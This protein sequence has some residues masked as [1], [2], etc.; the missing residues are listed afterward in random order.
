[1]NCPPPGR[2][3][4]LDAEPLEERTTPAIYRVVNTNDAGPGTLRTAI[5]K[6]NANPG[7]D[8]IAFAIP[9]G[10]PGFTDVN[11]NGQLNVGDYWTISLSSAL[12]A[13]TERVVI[14]GWSQFG[15][16]YNGR[17]LVA[18]RGANAGAGA[19]GLR[20]VNHSGSIVR[21]LVINLFDGNGIEITGGGSHRIQGNRIGTN[22]PGTQDRGN[23]GA[24]VFIT[25]S[26]QN[27]IGGGAPGRRNLIS[28]NDLQGIHIEGAAATGNLIL[29]NLIGT[30]ATGDLAIGNGT[31]LYLGDGIR[32]EGGGDNVI[33]GNTAKL[34]NVISGNFDDGIDIR[35]GSTG[36][37]VK[38]NLIGVR[39]SGRAALGNGADGVYIENASQNVIGG[40]G[41]GD[42]NVIGSNGYNGVFLYGDSDSNAVL[43][44]F[45]GTNSQGDNLGNGFFADFADGIFLAQFGGAAGPSGNTLQANKIAFNA[46]SGIAIDVALTATTTVGNLITRNSVY[47]NGGADGGAEI[48]LASNGVTPNDADDADAGPNNLQ[49]FP[50]ILTHVI[51]DGGTRTLTGSFDGAPNT[52]Y[53]LEFFASPAAGEG[54]QFLGTVPVPTGG[55][56]TAT[57]FFTYTPVS[58]MPFITITATN[59]DTLDT[60]EFSATAPPAA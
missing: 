7:A 30:R 39:A 57:W 15:G 58:G 6:A 13:I 50:V 4:R 12:P 41:S 24:G 46:D 40:L 44:N 31:Q 55:D 59:L 28:G 20:L 35:D 27:A 52:T 56:G 16:P 11:G 26:S 51:N 23:H 29:G 47:G 45:I 32:I 54:R 34:R 10:V 53:R 21:G 43:G 37:S 48:D 1:M 17:P 60:S 36:N 14:N 38:G 2:R 22:A 42:A 5:I 3:V 25:D 9:A 49:N 33:G 8:A 18:L 19:D